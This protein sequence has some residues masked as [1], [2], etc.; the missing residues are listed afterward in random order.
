MNVTDRARTASGHSAAPI[1]TPRPTESTVLAQVSH[2]L[3]N[4]AQRRDVDYPAFVAALHDNN[5]LWS[6]LAVDVAQPDNELPQ[7][8]RARIFWL[9][10]FTQAETRKLLRG[11]GD[12]GIMIEVNAAV[13]QGLRGTE[14]AA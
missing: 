3:R 14:V 11:K 1:R 10:E 4:A 6:T 8:L 9:A 13:L 7:D 2:R 5:N 12:V